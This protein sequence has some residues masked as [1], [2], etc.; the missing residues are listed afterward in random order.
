MPTKLPNKTKSKT[1]AKPQI[2]AVVFDFGGVL[3]ID[4]EIVIE[5]KYGFDKLPKATKEYYKNYLYYVESGNGSIQKLYQI[6]KEVF[7]YPGSAKDI[8]TLI[9][10]APL[11]KPMWAL[12]QA[13]RKG[14][15]VAILT[16]NKKQFPQRTAKYLKISLKGISVFNS[17]YIGMRK[18]SAEIFKY[19]AKKL[20]V[21][22]NQMV[23]IDDIAK[24][25]KGAKAVGINTIHF[26]G[27]VNK[28]HQALKKLGV[29]VRI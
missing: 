28:V 15:K 5:K 9:I 2:K 19:T 21:K 7:K 16:N 27:N 6:T 10:E 29:A 14:Y 26:T 8:E 13:L 18:P 25:I 17:A 22:P 24:N 3:I 11:I 1:S 12:A 4:N 23:F 20:S